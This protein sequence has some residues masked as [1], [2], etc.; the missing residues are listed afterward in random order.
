MCDYGP[1]LAKV[2]NPPWDLQY[3]FETATGIIDLCVEFARVVI[4][5]SS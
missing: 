4:P 5:S 1:K 3:P 2:P